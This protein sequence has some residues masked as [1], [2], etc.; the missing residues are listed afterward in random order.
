MS[1]SRMT[2]ISRWSLLRDTRSSCMH[3]S[4]AAGESGRSQRSNIPSR[5][6]ADLAVSAVP[7][8]FCDGFV[9]MLMR[10]RTCVTVHN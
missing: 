4:I 10:V 1:F 7:G 3:A 6:K 2:R 8:S 9:V 5:T